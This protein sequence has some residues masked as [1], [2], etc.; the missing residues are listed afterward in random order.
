MKTQGVVPLKSEFKPT[1]KVLSRKPT[2]QTTNGPP[3]VDQLGLNEDDEDQDTTK[4][5]LTPEERMQKAQK[6][7]EE[8][9]RAY[10]ERRRELFGKDSSQS[11][12]VS[13]KKGASPRNQS[14]NNRNNDSRPSSSTSIKTRQLFDPNESA[15]PENLRP[16]KKE[17][18]LREIHP[19]REPKAPDGNGFAGFGA[20]KRGEHST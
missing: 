19:I 7:R 14:R 4:T 11:T 10:E 9:Q 1:V 3:G 18:Q 6:E 12:S 16:Q 20:S 17:S 15:K 13:N 2:S 8:K 5:A